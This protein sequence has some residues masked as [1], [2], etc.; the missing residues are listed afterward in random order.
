M[1]ALATGWALFVPVILARDDDVRM[2]GG[3]GLSAVRRSAAVRGWC[4]CHASRR[5]WCLWCL[6]VVG[7]LQRICAYTCGGMCL[8]LSACV[9][10]RGVRLDGRRYCDAVWSQTQ[11]T[12]ARTFHHIKFSRLHK[13]HGFCWKMGSRATSNSLT[14]DPLDAGTPVSMQLCDG[15]AQ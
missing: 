7:W 10:W 1:G 5:G 3:T 15:R 8:W 9:C 6:G 13:L 14:R 4:R 11:H 12:R 2:C